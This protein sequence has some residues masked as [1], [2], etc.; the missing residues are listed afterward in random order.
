M[1]LAMDRLYRA[2][3]VGLALLA[4]ACGHQ[5]PAPSHVDAPY[6]GKLL[7]DTLV[8]ASTTVL[9]TKREI[10]IALDCGPLRSAV[11]RSDDAQIDRA[12]RAG[13][14]ARLPAGVTL[15][16]P[17]FS[18]HNPQSAPFVV[19]DDKFA[20]ELCTPNSFDVVKT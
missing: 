7:D 6:R 4:A 5:T 2:A 16:T 14:A 3:A 17:P 11:D 18:E 13:A 12:V 20:G 10:L 8:E 19:T 1:C 15:Y 9:V